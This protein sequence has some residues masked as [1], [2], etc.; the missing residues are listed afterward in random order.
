MKNL[1]SLFLCLGGVLVAC[2]ACKDHDCSDDE[3]NVFR[4]NAFTGRC[5]SCSG[6]IGYNIFD[7]ARIQ[8]TR[9]AECVD[10]SHVVLITL[11]KGKTAHDFRYD[12][13]YDFNFRGARFDSAEL[14]FNQIKESD[15]RGADLRL[16]QFGYAEIDGK[17][18]PFTIRPENG[19]CT[20]HPAWIQC[21]R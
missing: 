11:V 13:L 10:L 9:N 19:N 8:E 6:K 21:T 14:Y 1:G 5:E 3:Q 17:I 2:F 7:L 12:S 15:F 20:D 16:L 18:D 4:Y